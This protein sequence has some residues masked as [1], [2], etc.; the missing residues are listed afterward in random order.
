AQDSV[1][2]ELFALFKDDLDP[3]QRGRDLEAVL[4]R[5]FQLDGILI[6]ESFRRKG[7]GGHTIEQ[8]DGAV[9]IAGHLYLVEVKWH[10]EPIDVQ[11][12]QVLLSRLFLRP[13][14]RGIFIAANGYTKAAEDI[15][16]Q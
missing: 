7:E 6:R 8:I 10:K 3:H 1:K 12:V 15:R 14:A 11:A 9:E 13:E 5:L 16:Q 4:N 2:N